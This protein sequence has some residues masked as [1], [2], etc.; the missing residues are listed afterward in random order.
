M[1][2]LILLLGLL[3]FEDAQGRTS[4][5]MVRNDGSKGGAI[6]ASIL[7]GSR[8]PNCRDKC[9]GCR[10]CVPVLFIVNHRYH[11]KPTFNSVKGSEAD[12][13]PEI[14]KCKCGKNIF[15]P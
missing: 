2:L 13:Y 4:Q 9:K 1:T 6:G 7:S 12:Y 8:P 10:P 14:W 15:E 5:E 11:Q 3:N